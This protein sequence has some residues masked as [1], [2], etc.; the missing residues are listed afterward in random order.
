MT[1]P[2]L[3]RR[4]SRESTRKEPAFKDPAGDVEGPALAVRVEYH[5]IFDGDGLAVDPVYYRKAHILNAAIQE[6]G[7]GKYQVRTTTLSVAECTTN[8]R[9]HTVV[10]VL[11]QRV[12]LVCVSVCCMY[13][14]KIGI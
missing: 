11:R 14:R 4:T 1:S 9:L 10:F 5:D 8:A 6:I 3:P 12:R 7:M 13:A 2:E